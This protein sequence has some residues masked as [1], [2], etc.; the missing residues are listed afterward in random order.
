MMR[1]T[2][3]HRII[4]ILAALLA[5]FT[6]TP[7]AVADMQGVDVSN[8]QCGAD[9]YD[10]QADFV[11]IGTTWGVG[12]FSNNCLSWG[13]NTDANRMI[14]DTQNSGKAFGIYH[15]AMGNNP[16]QEAEFFYANTSNYWRH[17][18]VA[19][20]WEMDDNP[21]WGNW[22]WVRRFMTRA[23]QLS[24][25]VR[26]VLYTMG[27]A[28]SS[29]PSDLRGR[30]ALWVASYATMNPTSYQSQP[31]QL[32]AYGESMLQY[33]ATGVT[34]TINPV[35]LNIFRGDRSAWDRIANPDGSTSTPTPTPSPAPSQPSAPDLEDLATRTIRG[36]FGNGVDRINALGANYD[37]VMQIV[38]ARLGGGGVDLNTLAWATIRGDFGNGADRVNALGGN[39]T[40]VMQ[41]VNQLLGA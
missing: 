16:E 5:V 27:S 40:A 8:W 3:Q 21:A 14:A 23:E 35:D 26:P 37:T 18:I 38:N 20:D 33:S 9:V 30:Y 2:I 28:A 41:I 11:I 24:G 7:A 4:T 15:Y 31:W 22:D 13:V 29:I 25:G 6:I 19:L 32:G 36:D 34:N 17:G 39:Y 12:G 10:L 1:K